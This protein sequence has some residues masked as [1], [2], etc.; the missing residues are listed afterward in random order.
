MQFA[1]TQTAGGT[2]SGIFSVLN[3]SLDPTLAAITSTLSD[4][5][6]AAVQTQT[7]C[8]TALNDVRN[9]YNFHTYAMQTHGNAWVPNNYNRFSLA[10]GVYTTYPRNTAGF[11]L[12]ACPLPA[13]STYTDLISTG[14]NQNL[15]TYVNQVKN[16]FIQ[17]FS[18]LGT[19]L[20]AL[21]TNQFAPHTSPDIE[22]LPFLPDA[23]DLFSAIVTLAHLEYQYCWH[24]SDATYSPG[25]TTA[26]IYFPFT[27]TGTA[28]SGTLTATSLN[29]ATALASSLLSS[30]TGLVMIPILGNPTFTTWFAD[31]ILGT[32]PRI[33]VTGGSASTVTT[34]GSAPFNITAASF[35]C[36]TNSLYHFGADNNPASVSTPAIYAERLSLL[37]YSMQDTTTLITEAKLLAGLIQ[38]HETA[39]KAATPISVPGYANTINYYSTI[40]TGTGATTMTTSPYAAFTHNGS[41]AFPLIAYATGGTTTRYD[42]FTATATLPVESE[43]LYTVVYKYTYQVGAVTFDNVSTPSAYSAFIINDS[44]DNNLLVPGSGTLY[45][46]TISNL[47]VL[48]NTGQTNY[49]VANVTVQ[50]YRTISNGTTFYLVAEVPNGTTSVTDS[51]D[52]F[53]LQENEQLYIT[54]GTVPNDTPPQAKYIT[55]LNGTG[56]YGN[57]TESGASLP[58]RIRQS[59]SESIDSCPATFFDDLDDDLTGLSN[60]RGYVVAF[61]LNSLY[62]LE[63]GFNELGQGSLAHERITDTVGYVGHNTIVRTEFG[64][65]FC[66]TNGIYMTDGYS[67]QRVSMEL[68]KTYAALVATAQ[69]VK[70][71]SVVYLEDTRRIVWNFMTDS[72]QTDCSLSWTLDLNWGIS[73]QCSFT[74]MSGGP[75]HPGSWSPSAMAFFGGQWIRA[76]SRGYIFVH[77]DRWKCNPL[78]NTAI[79]PSSWQLIPLIYDYESNTTNLGSNKFKK[80]GSKVTVQAENRSDLSLAINHKNDYNSGGFEP[81][82]P[83]R[84]RLNMRWR[85][86]AILWRD[87][88]TPLWG[89]DGMVDDFRRFPAGKLRFDWKTIQMT[90]ASVIIANSDVYGVCTVSADSGGTTTITFTASP[91]KYQWPL[92][93]AGN[94]SIS[95][96][97]P[98]ALTYS[99]PLPILTRSLSA[100]TIAT[101]TGV[102]NGHA[103][104]KWQISGIPVNERFHLNSYNI[105]FSVLSD[106]QNAY[107]GATSSDGG[108]NA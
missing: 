26:Q 49:D 72:S 97:D 50:L 6:A 71:I 81:L 88:T 30:P 77:N 87:S 25:S 32:G 94:F 54:G 17:H 19:F 22:N 59:I 14:N 55:I 10:L 58:Y 15:V 76:D 68:E 16:E 56:Y 4:P 51:L 57:I 24:F 34:G 107:H 85:D 90:N 18:N 36:A 96:Q 48:T 64:I 61:C 3:I 45:P 31:N 86:P 75:T 20:P 27:G 7:N 79:S 105:T 70:M 33:A 12:N 42:Y 11:G 66:G 46:R 28:G 83:I 106:E 52:D 89:A 2:S 39:G 100:L 37:D 108:A 35:F 23:T 104:V 62:R 93:A 41:F 1:V 60:Y 5:V 82:V 29:G 91:T 8:I 99:A 44:P 73:E 38:A 40:T 67:F 101:A 69:Q 80:W 63:N 102:P 103:S 74:T 98:S 78:V 53:T 47:P 13:I 43:V 95:L 65:F 21:A 84:A 9:K 92:N